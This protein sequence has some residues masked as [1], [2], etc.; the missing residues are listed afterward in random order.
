M[1]KMKDT[2]CTDTVLVNDCIICDVEAQAIAQG[3]KAWSC[4]ISGQPLCGD[5]AW[6]IMMERSL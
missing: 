4:S 1:A 2:L 5:H 6:E 3:L